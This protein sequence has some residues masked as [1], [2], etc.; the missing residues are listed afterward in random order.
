MRALVTRWALAVALLDA[1]GAGH[2]PESAAQ[3]ACRVKHISAGLCAVGVDNRVWCWGGNQNGRIGDGT[4][5]SSAVPVLVS[6]PQGVSAVASDGNTCALT[7]GGQVWCWGE[8]LEYLPGD[9]RPSPVR[10]PRKL[11][12]S[13]ER[14]T[15]IDVMQLEV[16]A[17]TERGA[18]WLWRD[19]GVETISADGPVKGITGVRSLAAGSRHACLL[20][21]AAGKES[22]QCWGE[23]NEY[24]QLGGR[25]QPPD[26][27]RDFSDKLIAVPLAGPFRN[28][29]AGWLTSCAIRGEAGPGP[30]QGTVWCWGALWLG[31]PGKLYVPQET[32]VPVGELGSDNVDVAIMRGVVCARKEEG[33][34]SCWG[35]PAIVPAADGALIG[36]G[37]VPG[38]PAPAIQL[39]GVQDRV[40]ALLEDGSMWCWGY[41]FEASP[42]DAG[43]ATVSAWA[44]QRVHFPGCR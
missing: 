5:T 41:F 7:P 40:C 1:C 13:L 37:V 3:P 10:G 11:P 29:A 18:L 30:G 43:F 2:P 39:D 19:A 23:G 16:T 8:T 9:L 36:M 34:I 42:S 35:D 28:I 17:L 4:R 15:G 20:S 21:S 6:L 26:P 24:G 14:V 27:R 12:S 33:T 31:Q 44:A 32:P 38:L 22:V 25:A